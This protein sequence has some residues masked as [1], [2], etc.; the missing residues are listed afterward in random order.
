MK[1]KVQE[2][3]RNRKGQDLSGEKI[4]E[5]FEDIWAE[6]A[7][8]RFEI[9]EAG[10]ERRKYRSK[11]SENNTKLAWIRCASL[12]KNTNTKRAEKATSKP[13]NE[14]RGGKYRCLNLHD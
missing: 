4:E 7:G 1:S 12:F 8:R 6:A 5:I 14:A 2:A 11:C 13:K 3:I 10:R 9:L